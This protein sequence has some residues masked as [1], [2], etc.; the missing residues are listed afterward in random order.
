MLYIVVWIK[1]QYRKVLCRKW[2]HNLCVFVG[3]FFFSQLKVIFEDKNRTLGL[4][5]K[6]EATCWQLEPSTCS[7]FQVRIIICSHCYVL[8][9]C[10]SQNKSEASEHR[11]W[12]RWACSES[13][14]NIAILITLTPSLKGCRVINL[15]IRFSA[16]AKP[17]CTD[18]QQTHK[19]IQI[20]W[21]KLPLLFEYIPPQLQKLRLPALF[22]LPSRKPGDRILQ[23][24]V[25][26]AYLHIKSTLTRPSV[27]TWWR[28]DS[29]EFKYVKLQFQCF[30]E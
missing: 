4:C 23:P 24:L 16:S 7:A 5:S 19:Q 17:G 12:Q 25:L 8:P 14:I 29:S 13:L 20:V 26:P 18:T 6:T 2:S 15:M 22:I 9:K 3:P 21:M 1:G 11:H 27:F 30:V 28:V 10:G